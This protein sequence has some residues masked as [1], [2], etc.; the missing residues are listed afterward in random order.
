M[1]SKEQRGEVI[2]SD[3]FDDYEEEVELYLPDLT[4]EETKQLAKCKTMRQRLKFWLPRLPAVREDPSEEVSAELER[5]NLVGNI[6]DFA[7]Q[8]MDDFQQ[9]GFVENLAP[10]EL[11]NWILS[12]QNIPKALY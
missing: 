10:Y 5:Q 7:F 8:F 6:M 4:E 11:V 1:S 2:T 12:S 3:V 9:N